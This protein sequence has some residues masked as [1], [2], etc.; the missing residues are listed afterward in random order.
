LANFIF[1]NTIIKYPYSK[2]S[3]AINNICFSHMTLN[4]NFPKTVP[5]LPGHVF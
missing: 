3:V 4:L 5:F 2:I 1:C